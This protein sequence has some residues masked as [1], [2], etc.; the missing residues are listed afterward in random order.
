M[1]YIMN[2]TLLLLSDSNKIF[3]SSLRVPFPKFLKIRLYQINWNHCAV[4]FHH[5][6]ALNMH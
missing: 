2:K 4:Q 1:L 3:S 5:Y 6:T